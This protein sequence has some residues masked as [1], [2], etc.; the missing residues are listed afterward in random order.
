M[1]ESGVTFDF[2]QLVMD[3]EFARMIK[4][5]VA[6]I[7]VDDEAM[8]IDDI[9][10]V[11]NSGDFLSLA[12]T[13]RHMREQSEVKL[14]DRRIRE[15]WESDGCSDMHQRA[16]AKAREILESHDPMPL[17]DGIQEEMAAIITTAEREVG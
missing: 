13:F 5:A 11:G 2:G 8:A 7:R 14:I 6:G 16:L 1:I 9:H 15:E 4:H 3:A 17:P 10:A 12:A